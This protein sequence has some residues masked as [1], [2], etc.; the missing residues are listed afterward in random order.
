MGHSCAKR[1]K[2]WSENVLE[3]QKVTRCEKK[4]DLGEW[5]LEEREGYVEGVGVFLKKGSRPPFF[6]N[7]ERE[8]CDYVILFTSLFFAQLNGYLRLLSSLDGDQLRRLAQ[9]LVPYL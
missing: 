4:N 7:F 1:E 9:S 5:C 6:R 8:A 2:G 3:K